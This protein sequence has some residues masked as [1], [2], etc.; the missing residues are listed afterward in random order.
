MG[1]CWVY[2]GSFDGPYG[3]PWRF[4]KGKK[5]PEV[6]FWCRFGGLDNAGHDRIIKILILRA[7][8]MFMYCF[9]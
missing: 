6:L 1:V 9:C 2:V 3:V 7:S 5:K 8:L 4:V